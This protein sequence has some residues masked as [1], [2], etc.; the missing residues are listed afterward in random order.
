MYTYTD[1]FQSLYNVS[2]TADSRLDGKILD[3]EAGRLNM[4][5]DKF[6]ADVASRLTPSRLHSTPNEG[7]RYGLTPT[8]SFLKPKRTLTFDMDT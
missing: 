1:F 3:R 4:T 6:G 8:N 5:A 7:Q 2:T